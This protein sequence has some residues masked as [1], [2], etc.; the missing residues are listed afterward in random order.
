MT[1]QH[2]LKSFFSFHIFPFID[3][4]QL[5]ISAS[6][7]LPVFHSF[8]K[9]CSLLSLTPSHSLSFSSLVNIHHRFSPV[10]LCPPNLNLSLPSVSLIVLFF[11]RN[12]LVLVASQNNSTL[13]Q[14]H[15][16]N[17]Y[18][19]YFLTKHIALISPCLHSYILCSSIMFRYTCQSFNMLTD[20]V[21]SIYFF[22]FIQPKTSLVQLS[23][24]IVN[25]FV[26]LSLG[27]LITVATL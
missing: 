5:F 11:L 18:L 17:R 26:C 4:W 27:R 15:Q 25:Q 22:K 19:K 20:G 9:L 10:C 16:S 2:V 23:Q 13:Y 14:T 12:N 21:R 6:T 1:P 8:K 3:N 7:M 24:N